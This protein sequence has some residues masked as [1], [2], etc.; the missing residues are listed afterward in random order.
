MDKDLGSGKPRH[1]KLGLK[2]GEL[3][4]VDGAFGEDVFSDVATAGGIAVANDRVGDA[5]V[6]LLSVEKVSAL[7]KVNAIRGAMRDDC[8]IWVVWPKG[9]A[10]INEN[11]VREHALRGDLVDVKVMS[12]SA[13]HSGLRLVVRKELRRVEHGG[14]PAPV[15]KKKAPP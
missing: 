3:V 13:T 15:P 5:A 11:I 9:H 7:G 1:E 2:A 14:A 6:V 12:W 10:L 8:A 4:C